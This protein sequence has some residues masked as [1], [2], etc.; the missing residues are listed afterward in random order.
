MPVRVWAGLANGKGLVF[1]AGVG[2][3]K[4]TCINMMA[5]GMKLHGSDHGLINK[6]KYS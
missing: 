6:K 5:C 2:D 1:E 4:V 3:T